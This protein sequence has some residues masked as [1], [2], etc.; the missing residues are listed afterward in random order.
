MVFLHR[1]KSLH[2]RHPW[3][4]AVS[5]GLFLGLVGQ[6]SRGLY[7][8][9][10][11]RYAE[12]ARETLA[13]GNWLLPVLNGEPHLTKPPLTYWAIGAGTSILGNTV[14]GARLYLVAG[15][16]FTVLAVC[17]LERALWSDKTN[18]YGA[19]VYATSPFA[20]AAANV[21]STDT[22]L[23][24]WGTWAFACYWLAVRRQSHH[25]VTAMWLFIGLAVFTK[26]P[27]GFYPL[28]AIGMTH[29]FMRKRQAS[30]PRLFTSWGML[31]LVLVGFSWYI[32]IILRDHE[33]LWTWIREEILGRTVFS[34]HSRLSSQPRKVLENYVP[35]VMLGTGPWLLLLL[36]KT[37]KMLRWSRL[38]DLLTDDAF[39][40][41]HVF[42]LTAIA[43]P[44]V[45]FSMTTSRLPLY[46]VPI[47]PPMAVAIGRG[48]ECL[49]A[50]GAFRRAVFASILVVSVAFIAAAK[51]GSGLPGT[52][53]DGTTLAHALQQSG[54]T[55]DDAHL[56][57]FF[58]EP[59]NGLSF[60]LGR[61]LPTVYVSPN[62]KKDGAFT[63]AI[64]ASD[65]PLLTLVANSD[66]LASLA[67]EDETGHH[68]PAGTRFIMRQKDAKVVR[69]LLT[70][71]RMEPLL[72]T[73]QWQVLE[74][75]QPLAFPTEKA[76]TPTE[77]D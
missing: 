33:V 40:A 53:K 50:S 38:R 16:V 70:D 11:G 58:R 76:D 2:S 49:C 17:V 9:T 39:G 12:C 67:T 13:S 65:L 34:G 56:V 74:L 46:L 75:Q 73:E 28:I 60:H 66:A 59:M 69:S 6:G 31:A 19:L 14:W 36:Y 21:V 29:L 51:A 37:R 63:K 44:I 64:S 48:I 25:L 5:I 8:S 68:I 55:K 72:D 3:V 43:F 45:L 47:F 71:T 52:W 20:I 41:Q 77:A 57:V 26:G 61:A 23:T 30:I 18:F 1:L 42:L 35:I 24:L 62:A 32:Y 4:L 10:E 15:F 7:E 27:V 22:L 54:V